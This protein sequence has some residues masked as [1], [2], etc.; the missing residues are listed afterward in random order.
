MCWD[1]SRLGRSLADL[2]HIMNEMASA[3][4]DLF[5]FQQAID[6]TTP[7]GKLCFQ[8]FA[9]L[10]EWEREMIRERV[11]SGIAAARRR[12][13]K[14]GRPSKINSSVESA[15]RVLRDK[16]VG[17]KQI[18]RQ[19]EIGVGSVYKALGANPS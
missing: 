12:G 11:L 15:V 13:A 18:A 2:V 16:G 17:I 8:I 9:S 1:I 3:Q 14:L 7:A 4:I 10:A 5:F 6:T 19:L